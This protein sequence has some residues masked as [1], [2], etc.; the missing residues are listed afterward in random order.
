MGHGRAN[1]LMHSMNSNTTLITSKQCGHGRC[2]PNFDCIS[3]GDVDFMCKDRKN[4]DGSSDDLDVCG[5]DHD[6]V[7]D[8]IAP[9]EAEFPPCD[10]VD[11]MD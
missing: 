1:I 7:C 10:D 8:S 3:I 9:G 2:P 4:T 6:N 11:T 5:D